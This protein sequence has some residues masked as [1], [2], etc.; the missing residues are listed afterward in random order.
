[1]TRDARLSA[2]HRGDGAVCCGDNGLVC[3][4]GAI[5]TTG[6]QRFLAALSNLSP[7]P[8]ADTLCGVNPPRWVS[9]PRAAPRYPSRRSVPG[10]HRV[11]RKRA[12]QRARATEREPGQPWNLVVHAPFCRSARIRSKASRNRRCSHISRNT[13]SRIEVARSHSGSLRGIC[14][15]RRLR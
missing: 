5:C 6:A 7:L 4:P 11:C 9:A 12:I 2:L 14:Q 15:S 13:A 3:L 1:M 10:T 8:L